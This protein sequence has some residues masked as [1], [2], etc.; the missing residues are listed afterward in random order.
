MKGLNEAI[1]EIEGICL[2]RYRTGY[3]A[4]GVHGTNIE[5]VMQG[6]TDILEILEVGYKCFC[7]YFNTDNDMCNHSPDDACPDCEGTGGLYD[8]KLGINDECPA[9]AGTGFYDGE[10]E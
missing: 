8:S 4:S 1:K 3:K 2:D 9:C 6:F 7:G 5:W 10:G